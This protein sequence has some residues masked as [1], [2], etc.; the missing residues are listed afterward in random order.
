VNVGAGGIVKELAVGGNDYGLLRQF[1]RR[2]T[3][4]RS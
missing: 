4:L 1:H 2:L 3:V